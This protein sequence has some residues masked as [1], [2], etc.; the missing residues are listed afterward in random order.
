M[1]TLHACVAHKFCLDFHVGNKPTNVRATHDWLHNRMQAM[2]KQ[3]PTCLHNL[4]D[5]GFAGLTSIVFAQRK[6]GRS[7]E[8]NDFP[9]FY[10]NC[11]LNL[12][13]I[14]I[15]NTLGSLDITLMLHPIVHRSGL[16]SSLD[17]ISW[18]KL[19]YKNLG[20]I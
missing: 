17:I 10:K 12:I 14:A 8:K 2:H 16:A 11:H 15:W 20:G 5:H 7:Q 4:I 3:L 1:Q 9:S 18:N 13:L 19:R 6:A